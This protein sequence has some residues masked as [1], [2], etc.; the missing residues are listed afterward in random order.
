[1]GRTRIGRSN[2]AAPY[3]PEETKKESPEL[4]A[5]SLRPSSIIPRG[6]SQQEDKKEDYEFDLHYNSHSPSSKRRGPAENALDFMLDELK[7][8]EGPKVIV[9]EGPKVRKSDYEKDD[10]GLNTS[11][12]ANMNMDFDEG[13]K[14][15][16]R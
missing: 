9:P 10:E 14:G 2:R 1:M 7:S 4:T 3:I 11:F 5:N 13:K 6:N 15:G 8:S 12:L 16:G